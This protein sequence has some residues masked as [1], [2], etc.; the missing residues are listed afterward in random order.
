MKKSLLFLVALLGLWAPLS[1]QDN[2][3]DCFSVVPVFLEFTDSTCQ[4]EVTPFSVLSGNLQNY[5]ESNFQISIQDINPDNGGI[6]DGVGPY[7]YE[8]TC[9]DNDFFDCGGFSPCSG[10]VS[11]LGPLAN[12]VSDAV[13]ACPLANLPDS[14]T[15][16]TQDFEKVCVNTTVTYTLSAD[17]LYSIIEVQVSGSEDFI[18]YDNR[19]EVT[20]HAIGIG[21]VS[22]H[23][24]SSFAS[25]SASMVNVPL[26]LSEWSMLIPSAA[27][28]VSAP[29]PDSPPVDARNVISPADCS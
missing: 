29:A 20:W 13:V 22:F 2:E 12:V 25:V 10:V 16:G 19:V 27:N 24:S 9:V 28:N 3:L 17:S 7:T 15:G 1:A 4:A 14:T 8:V 26:V 5:N 6:M 11:G 23:P 18:V 21:S